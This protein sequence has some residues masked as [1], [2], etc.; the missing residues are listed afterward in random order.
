MKIMKKPK[1]VVY[2]LFLLINLSSLPILSINKNID[3]LKIYG[4][5]I[6]IVDNFVSR[7]EIKCSKIGKLDTITLIEHFN[8]T[9]GRNILTNENISIGDS[10]IINY[11]HIQWKNIRTHKNWYYFYNYLKFEDSLLSIPILN[12][13]RSPKSRRFKCIA[14]GNYAVLNGFLVEYSKIFVQYFRN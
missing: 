8:C 12:S 6:T 1:K 3:T 2:L 11:S 10:L 9:L 4:M 7:L 13:Y 5:N 14:N